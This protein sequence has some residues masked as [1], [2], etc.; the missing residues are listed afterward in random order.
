MS[1]TGIPRK[2]GE[3]CRGKMK[4]NFSSFGNRL[5][6][7][8]SSKC[9]NGSMKN[10]SLP[11]MRFIEWKICLPLENLSFSN[12]VCGFQLWIQMQKRTGLKDGRKVCN[13]RSVCCGALENEGR[14]LWESF[15]MIYW[16]LLNFYSKP[17]AIQP[18]GVSMWKVRCCCWLSPWSNINARH[19]G[20]SKWNST[21]GLYF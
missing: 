11:F 17:L 16:S 2:R 5:D 15:S 19:K 6:N 20:F 4:Y 14:W 3:L 8:S 10:T 18:V 1:K 9:L 12:C 13:S 7:K 21:V